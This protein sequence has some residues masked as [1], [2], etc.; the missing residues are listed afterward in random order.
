M[1]GGGRRCGGSLWITTQT[2][3]GNGSITANGGAG[4]IVS[5]EDGGGGGGGRV[6][7]YHTTYTFSGALTALGGSGRQYGGAGTVYTKLTGQTWGEV[8]LDNGG[9]NGASTTL[10]GGAQTLDNLFILGRAQL[11]VPTNGVLTLQ[12]AVLTLQTNFGLMVNGQLLSAA[13]PNG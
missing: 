11:E 3:A 8:R 7:I 1:G 12:P 5:E 10:P 6:A 2:L 13:N 4:P 9:N